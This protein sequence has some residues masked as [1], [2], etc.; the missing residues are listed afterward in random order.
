MLGSPWS[1]TGWIAILGALALA[2][3]VAFAI[4]LLC[5]HGLEL[6]PTETLKER[7]RSG[8]LLAE[9]LVGPLS[10]D[11]H[12]VGDPRGEK[13]S[14]SQR[15]ELRLRARCLRREMGD[16]EG[17]LEAGQAKMSPLLRAGIGTSAEAAGWGSGVPLN[18]A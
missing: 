13:G 7:V 1:P 5:C 3:L 10:D 9:I 8:F 14:M 2:V 12:Q 11:S 6:R 17:I 4:P 18:T 16:R 15:R